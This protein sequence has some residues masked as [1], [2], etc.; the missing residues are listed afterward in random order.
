MRLALGTG[1]STIAPSSTGI[2]VD[3]SQPV[4]DTEAVQLTA[5]NGAQVTAAQGI[6]QGVADGM[7]PRES[8]IQ[9]LSAF[10]NLPITAAERIMGTVGTAGFRAKTEDQ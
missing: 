6:V 4:V 5:L 3:S 1:G 10:F 9:M 2:P 8:G 7:L